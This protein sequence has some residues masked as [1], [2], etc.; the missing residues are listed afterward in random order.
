MPLKR[1]RAATRTIAVP[2]IGAVLLAAA[3]TGCG[4]SSGGAAATT[5]TTPKAAAAFI[6]DVTT[7][8]SRGQ[9]GRL[10]DTLVPAD[11]AAVSRAR[12]MACQSN[13]GFEIQKFKV[14]ET[15][16]D[17]I[18]VGGKQTPSTAVSVQVTSDDGMTTATMHAVSVGGTWRWTLPAADLAAYAKGKCPTS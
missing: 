14:L 7:Q 13:E 6:Q 5:G 15:Y 16:A 2:L 11:Q 9:S 8:F 1:P 17:T 10:W 3:A 4:S 18:D 12:Y